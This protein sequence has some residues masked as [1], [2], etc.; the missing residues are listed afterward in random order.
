M[1]HESACDCNSTCSLVGILHPPS[2]KVLF[3]TSAYVPYNPACALQPCPP[4]PS[5]DL[6]VEFNGYVP[7]VHGLLG[8]VRT[9]LAK[10]YS[11]L[12]PVSTQG[13]LC[14]WLVKE[15]SSCVGFEGLNTPFK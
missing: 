4:I 9:W 5:L 3:C 15:K 8:Q 14:L 13:L 6:R 2:P 7:D 12:M 1:D 10:R 11:A